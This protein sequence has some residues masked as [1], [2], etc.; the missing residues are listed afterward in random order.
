MIPRK[1]KDKE[2]CQKRNVSSVIS[3]SHV[4]FGHNLFPLWGRRK[5]EGVKRVELEW[6]AASCEAVQD[7]RLSGTSKSG[8][9][10]LRRET[11]KSQS[12]RARTSSRAAA[13]GDDFLAM[14]T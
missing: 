6:E 8:T 10:S 5:T 1:K 4:P 14:G 13:R 2:K 9:F 3:E 11:E 12:F 7:L